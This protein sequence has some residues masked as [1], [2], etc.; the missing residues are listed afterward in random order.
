MV[1]M[2]GQGSDLGQ[3]FPAE[4]QG[5]TSDNSVIDR[6]DEDRK[7]PHVIIE[8]AQ[9]PCQQFPPPPVFL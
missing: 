3:I 6:I 9:R 8:L 2:N 1:G 5:T 4:L 7:I